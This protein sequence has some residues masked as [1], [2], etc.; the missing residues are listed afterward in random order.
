MDNIEQSKSV[1]LAAA[2]AA[3]GVTDPAATALFMKRHSARMRFDLD[4]ELLI[5][6]E[7]I[8]TVFALSPEWVAKYKAPENISMTHSEYSDAM[9][10]GKQLDTTKI[11][12]VADR[13]VVK[14][15]KPG[16]MTRAEYCAAMIAGEQGLDQVQEW[17]D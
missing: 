2:L 3:H 5:D 7:P 6:S 12:I 13:P 15:P 11:R 8:G 10:A 16:L 14:I 1:K 4:G 9:R 17:N